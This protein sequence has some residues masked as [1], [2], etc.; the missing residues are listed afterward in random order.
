[1]LYHNMS[2]LK[3]ENRSCMKESSTISE[4]SMN[5]MIETMN[6]KS[7]KLSPHRHAHGEA[8]GPEGK[9]ALESGTYEESEGS[10]SD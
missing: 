1:M 10:C 5:S 3:V 7:M 9:L 4:E 2:L 6:K 8:G